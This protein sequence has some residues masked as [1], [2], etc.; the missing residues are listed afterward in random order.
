MLLL[1]SS[2][3]STIHTF[4][5]ATASLGMYAGLTNSA[6]AQQ[7]IS[8][9]LPF[10]QVGADRNKTYT[11][12]EQ[13][14]P[15]MIL[16]A[17]FSGDNAEHDAR[18][19][20]LEL[21]ERFRIPAYTHSKRYDYSQPVKGLGLDPYGDP[22]V[23]KYQTPMAVDEIAVLVG[24]FPSINDPG[25]EKALKS[26]KYVQPN[27][28]SG[29][30]A[31]SMRLA[32]FR[33]Y[34]KNL[35]SDDAKRRKGPLGSAFVTRNPLLPREYFAPVGFDKLVEQM[36]QGVQYSLLDCPGK[37]TVRVAT[38]RG[39]V[40]I[41]QKRVREIEQTGRMSSKLAE[42]GEKAHVLAEALRNR[43]VEAY[44]FHDRHESI[45]TV[46]SFNSMGNPRADGQI[47]INPAILKLLNTYGAKQQ[48]LPGQQ[49]QAGLMPG[50]LNGISFDVQ[51]T[52]VEVPRR[53]IASD[54]ARH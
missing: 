29:G 13:N 20:V 8:K 33:N 12:T 53:S 36:N 26:I 23:M 17:S 37:Y 7:A 46:G 14:G 25:I 5:L 9:L 1:R 18:K 43:G 30:A 11:L 28:L 45:V 50:S 52:A 42:A 35:S 39:N 38:F 10:R 31:T 49:S 34:F 44:E 27:S 41:D 3:K 47:E 15:W 6:V 40:I 2:W 21:R 16:A 22:K 4:M 19:L 54:Y 24:D 48:Q 32:S 51:P